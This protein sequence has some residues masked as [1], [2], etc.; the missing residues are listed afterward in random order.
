MAHEQ[1]AE[2]CTQYILCGVDTPHGLKPDGFSV[3][4]GGLR[5]RSLKAWPQPL[6]IRGGVV[7]AVQAGSTVW[8]GMPAEG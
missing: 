1:A 2:R 7:I 3:L 8:A 5:H 4:R 6:S